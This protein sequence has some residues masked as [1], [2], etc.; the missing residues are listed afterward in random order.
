MVSFD[1][2]IQTY[3]KSYQMDGLVSHVQRDFG[4]PGDFLAFHTSAVLGV[5]RTGVINRSS[6][7]FFEDPPIPLV[8]QK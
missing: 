3:F 8:E 1:E 4:S 5:V 6:P 7:F 2:D